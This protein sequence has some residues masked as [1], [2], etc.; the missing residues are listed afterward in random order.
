MR[1]F[2]ISAKS[3]GTNG[4]C[5]TFWVGAAAVIVIKLETLVIVV[6]AAAVSKIELETCITVVGAAAVFIIELQTYWCSSRQQ[7]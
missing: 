6:G 3:L 5:T 7:N 2:N 1:P 4:C